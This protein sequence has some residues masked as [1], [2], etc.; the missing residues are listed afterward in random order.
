MEIIE[1][2][3]CENCDKQ[4]TEGSVEY[5][6]WLPRKQSRKYCK[7]CNPENYGSFHKKEPWE[8]NQS[9]FYNGFP[10]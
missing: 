10:K 7:T 2:G 5:Y 1:I 9:L 8:I 6:D 4:S 3:I